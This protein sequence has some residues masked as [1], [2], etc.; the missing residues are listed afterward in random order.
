MSSFKVVICGAGIAG[1]E[2]LLR[3]RKLTGDLVDITLLSAATELSYRPLAILEPFGAAKARRYPVARI[4]ADSGAEWIPHDLTWVDRAKRTVHFSNGLELGYDALLLAVGGRHRRPPPHM[5]MFTD[6]NAT[7]VYS[8]ILAAIE[9]A[10]IRHLAFVMPSGPSWPLPL[11]ELALL[12]STRMRYVADL[13]ISF[14]TAEKLPLQPFGQEAGEVLARTMREAGITLFCDTQVRALGKQH[15]QLNPGG[16]L[17]PDLVITIPTITGPNVAGLAGDARDR[18]LPIDDRCRLVGADGHIF[19]AGDATDL[20]IKHGGV[21]AQQA[22][23]AAA[24]IAYLAGVG[25]PPAP[26]HPLIQGTVLTGADPLY[27]MAHLVAGHGWR[28]KVYSEPPWS[29]TEKVIAAELSPYLRG[30][31]ETLRRP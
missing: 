13:R 30:L 12:T 20:I 8:S 3:V 9:A 19:A 17:H 10:E 7:E 16:D 23:T 18:F 28:G 21:G 27:L 15:L 5:Q 31:D 1:I 26:L 11:Y 4:A 2:G 25:H 14:V 6:R 29:P 22:D 24:G